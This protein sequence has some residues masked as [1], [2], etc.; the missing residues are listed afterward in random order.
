MVKQISSPNINN[1]VNFGCA[2]CKKGKEIVYKL[3]SNGVN[4]AV[5]ERFLELK[6]PNT[7]NSY[8]VLVDFKN[9]QNFNHAQT[10]NELY[11]KAKSD[12]A[13]F[14]TEVKDFVK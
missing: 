3:Y 11:A 13:G 2:S 4:K 14:V 6:S 7:A 5:A 9:T 1:Q 10:I 8:G 12:I